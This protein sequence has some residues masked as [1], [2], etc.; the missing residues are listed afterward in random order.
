MILTFV[1]DLTIPFTN[2]PAESEV[3]RREG[4]P[5]G[6]RLSADA[7]RT[8]RPRR[9]DALTQLFTTGPWLPPE[10]S[11]PPGLSP[12]APHHHALRTA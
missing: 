5:A 4:P 2:N 3:R 8:R 9:L 10:P 7:G 6:L 1:H 11:V 12:S